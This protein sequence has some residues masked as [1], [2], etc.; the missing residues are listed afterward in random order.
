M[1]VPSAL[2][3][4][5]VLPESGAIAQ[6]RATVRIVAAESIDFERTDRI[7]DQPGRV[8]MRRMPDPETPGTD[9]IHRLVE[10]E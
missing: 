9:R 6:A 10:F 4:L 2:L 1:A 7:V 8:V 5:A 3:L